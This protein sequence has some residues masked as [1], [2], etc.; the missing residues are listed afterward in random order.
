[1]YLILILSGFSNNIKSSPYVHES[2]VLTS[3][4]DCDK[5][6]DIPP[7]LYGDTSKNRS[8]GRPQK[9]FGQLSSRSESLALECNKWKWQIQENSWFPNLKAKACLKSCVKGPSKV[10]DQGLRL[11]QHHFV[12]WHWFFVYGLV[13][14]LREFLKSAHHRCCRGTGRKE[15]FDLNF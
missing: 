10:Y 9:N 8:W 5:L 4:E 15:R 1:M 11:Q 12:V 2:R 3:L 14:I 6:I 7:R 13:L